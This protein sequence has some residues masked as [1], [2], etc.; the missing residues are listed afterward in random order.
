MSAPVS[1]FKAKAALF[2]PPLLQ[3]TVLLTIVLPPPAAKA[4]SGLRV[5]TF[6][7]E[8]T[9]R[10][11]FSNDTGT[12]VTCTAHG[13]PQPV[14]SWVLKDGT[15]ATQVPGLRKIAGN[16]TLYFPPFLAQYYRT[17][18]H[19]T[20]YRCRATNEAGTILSRNVQVQA[21]VRRQYQVH[22]ENSEVYLGNSA[23][24]KCAMPD[25][26]RPYVKVTSWQRGEEILLP[27]LSDVEQLIR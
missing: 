16:G 15:M 19:E 25:Y 11:L 5:P 12:Q 1:V 6:I 17:D 7:Q 26:V 23:L 18:V 20:T 21:V 9:P 24:I 4:T 3:I 27:D 14:V 8:P 10:L 13:N 2:A 22:V